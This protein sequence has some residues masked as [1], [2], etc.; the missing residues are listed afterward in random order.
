LAVGI[1]DRRR[2]RIAAV[3]STVVAATLSMFPLTVSGSGDA[4]VLPARVTAPADT[5]APAARAALVRRWP[6]SIANRKVRD[7]HGRVYLIRTFSSWGMASNLSKAAITS[8]LESV[9][10]NRFNGVTVWIGGG[11]N[12]G[13]DWSPRYRH[14]VTGR[15]FWT[16]RPWASSLGGAWASL[17]HLVSEARR[18]GI[19][20]WMSLNGGFGTYG[21]RADWEAV[22]NRSMRRA[23]VAIARRYRAAPNVGWH[24]MFDDFVTPASPA[25][26]R[27]EAFFDG[28]NDTEGASARPIRWVEVAN[29]STTKEQGWLRTPKLRATINSWY[30]YGSNSTQIA[31]AGYHQVTT[32]PVGDCEPPYDG[33]PHYAGNVGQQLRE[34]SYATFI[35]GGSLINYGHEDWWRFALTGLYT[36]GLGWRQVQRHSHTVQQSYAWKLLDRFVANRTWVPARRSFLTTGTGRGDTKAAVGRSG[37]AAVAYF[38]SR[39]SVVVNTTVIAGTKPVRL[40]WYNPTTGSFRTISASEAQRTRRSVAYPSAHRDGTRDWVLVVNVASG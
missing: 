31:E 24:V 21:A 5:D 40:R 22:T 29:G 36:E 38:P 28:V 14:Q 8:A 25:G 16:G 33:S 11:A 34:R 20:V 37:N 3:T 13:S 6:S 18:L 17:D 2:L 4:T 1:V 10:A 7:Q 35:E 26:Q 9:A 39:R 30:E 32:V 27:I 23:G 15:G 19:F 12:Y